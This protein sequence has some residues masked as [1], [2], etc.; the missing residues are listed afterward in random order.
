[1]LKNVN[2]KWIELGLALGLKKPTLDNIST[3]YHIADDR[4]REMLCC[5]LQRQDNCEAT[6]NWKSLAK[7]LKKLTVNHH[8]IAKAIH[9]KYVTN[10]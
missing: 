1:M 3:E 5:W 6:C 4:K 8:P 2:K 10:S 7:A 9:K